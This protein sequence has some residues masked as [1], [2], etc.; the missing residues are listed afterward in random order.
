MVHQINF[1]AKK[2]LAAPVLSNIKDISVLFQHLSSQQQAAAL[3]LQQCYLQL[4]YKFR[5]N[6]EFMSVG[7]VKLEDAHVLFWQCNAG[8]IDYFL[9]DSRDALGLIAYRWYVDLGHR[10]NDCVFGIT[11]NYMH[12][13]ES[14]IH[15]A[16][17]H[18]PYLWEY[19]TGSF[20]TEEK[21]WKD[22]RFS[23]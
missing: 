21:L 15:Y 19:N 11:Y 6:P 14:L 10:V 7:Y 5:I 23:T 8:S 3:W 9:L 22:Q 2:L 1:Y 12:S 17:T 4:P 13:Q 16:N 20:V 18:I